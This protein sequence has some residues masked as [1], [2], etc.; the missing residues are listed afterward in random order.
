[1]G[2]LD[3]FLSDLL[4]K[5]LKSFLGKKM[6]NQ[7]EKRLF[8]KY[9]MTLRE[10]MDDFEKFDKTLREFFGTGSKGV[11]RSVL[12]NFCKV[13]KIKGS[14]NQIILLQDENMTEKILEML[15]DKDY[16][17]IL[18]MLIDKPHTTYEILDKTDIPQASAY[19]KVESLV[20]AGLLVEDSRV[21]GERGRHSVK[22]T[23]VYR[24]LDLNIIKKNKVTVK[25]RMS[26]DMLKKSTI[27]TTQ[28]SI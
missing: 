5:E 17:K 6:I 2:G 3:L 28:Y 21:P 15:G 8:E 13:K 10:S 14:K 1:M 26:K 11:V 25:V 7:I 19:R 20:D 22:L 9:D 16:R 18:D 23:T 4:R 12:G 24:G 27:L